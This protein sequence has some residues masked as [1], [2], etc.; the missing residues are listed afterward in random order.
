MS[1]LACP[2]GDQCRAIERDSDVGPDVS[3]EKGA[4]FVGRGFRFLVC[5][6]DL[7]GREAHR[8]QQDLLLGAEVPVDG[9][10]ADVDGFADVVDTGCGVTPF[11]E[12]TDGGFEN[13]F[14]PI[15]WPASRSGVGCGRIRHG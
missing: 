3:L 10:A 12:E 1:G 15:R 2:Y 4:G 14:S 5:L 8:F 6:V 9:G 13:Q 7:I 11:V